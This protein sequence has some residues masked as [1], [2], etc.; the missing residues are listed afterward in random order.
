MQLM[1]TKT[2]Q[3]ADGKSSPW[4]HE[5]RLKLLSGTT[6][7]WLAWSTAVRGRSHCPSASRVTRQKQF[8]CS[9]SC[10]YYLC[11]SCIP[12]PSVLIYSSRCLWAILLIHQSGIFSRGAAEF[13]SWSPEGW[14][15]KETDLRTI[16]GDSHGRDAAKGSY[17]PG[18]EIRW[19]DT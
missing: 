12:C 1:K 7:A 14:V 9:A 2:A 16:C 4:P 8:V 10:C 15:H 3:T 18:L 17:N 6:C 11:R 5:E 19:Q 13:Q